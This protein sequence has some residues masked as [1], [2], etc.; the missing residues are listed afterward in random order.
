M[1][2]IRQG[3]REDYEYVAMIVKELHSF[4]VKGRPDIYKDSD[5][6]LNKDYYNMLIE[7]GLHQVF[8]L[9]KSNNIIG[10]CI[11]EIKE[12]PTREGL[13]TKKFVFIN[14]LC[15]K[16]NYKGNGYGRLLF[17][18]VRHYAKSVGGETLELGV[19]NFNKEAIEFYKHMGMN[20]RNIRMELKV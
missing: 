10:Y 18:E 15:I 8:V 1:C 20:I 11:I 2:I 14:D 6:P 9:E 17:K 13:V 12:T 16:N 5:V 4:H 3:K 7:S 19:W